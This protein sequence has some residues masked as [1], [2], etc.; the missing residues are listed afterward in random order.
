VNAPTLPSTVDEVNSIDSVDGTRR[1]PH[2][3]WHPLEC[4]CEIRS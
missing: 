2:N 4:L 3:A 1:E